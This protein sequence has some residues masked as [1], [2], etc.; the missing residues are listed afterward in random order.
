MKA[1][2]YISILL[3]AGLLLSACGSETDNTGGLSD[4]Q[5]QE[6]VT[7]P[8]NQNEN[9]T[10]PSDID[11]ALTDN[12]NPTESPEQSIGE[13]SSQTPEELVPIEIG[14]LNRDTGYIESVPM[15]E[16][17]TIDLNNDGRKDVITYNAVESNIA[18]YG[19]TVESFTI[20]SGDY[21]Y[22]LYLS[23]QGI[24]IQDPDLDQ[25]FITD[26]NTR[27]SYKEIALLDHGANGV[28]LTYFI[29]FVGSGTYCLGYVPYFPDDENFKINGDG[30]VESTLDLKLL[31]KWKAPA[32][33]QSGSDQLL[34]S[35]LK[36]RQPD[37]FYPYEDQN[38]ETVIQ[39][40]NLKL[41]K[42]RS[43]KAETVNATASDTAEVTFTQT[44]NEHWV[45]V[46]R[47]DEVE[48]WMYMENFETILSGATISGNDIIGGTRHNRR[49][50]F[51]NLLY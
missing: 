35:N 34:A 28:P 36:M 20:N 27:D 38:E 8:G 11:N 6:P 31:Q 26:L 1:G 2:K 45:Y 10:E 42:S 41:Y 49:D 50:V 23:D 12:T 32:V 5:I 7:Q 44:D 33:W 51:K 13:E 14:D 16:A 37:L 18:E 4:N 9:V 29:R 48:G 19:T 24:H 43:L 25:Y 17:C 22:T 40:K 15:G 3:A 21:K 46:K 39:L 30:S 47:D